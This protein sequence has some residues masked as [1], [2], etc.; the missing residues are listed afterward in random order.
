MPLA[1]PTN[2]VSTA[3]TVN[4]IRLEYDP[5][6]GADEYFIT[7]SNGDSFV[8]QDFFFVFTGLLNNTSHDFT[9]TARNSVNAQTSGPVSLLG[10]FTLFI[11]Q[12]YP[13][14]GYAGVKTELRYSLRN[15]LTLYPFNLV[16]L[17]EASV[18]NFVTI[19]SQNQYLLNFINEQEI[20][21]T[22]LLPDTEYSIRIT[23]IDGDNLA[24][25][26]AP[27]IEKII[28]IAP[29]IATYLSQTPTEADFSIVPA[30]GTESLLLSY[31]LIFNENSGLGQHPDWYGPSPHGSP[32]TWPFA[33][34]GT[35]YFKALM[36]T[37]TAGG[38]KSPAPLVSQA[39]TYGTPIPLSIE[40]Y[41]VT[42]N[43][44]IPGSNIGIGFS[45][46]GPANCEWKVFINDIQAT[47]PAPSGGIGPVSA[48]F[49]HTSLVNVKYTITVTNGINTISEDRFWVAGTIMPAVLSAVGEAKFF[50]MVDITANPLPAVFAPRN[51]TPDLRI[52]ANPIA[53]TANIYYSGDGLPDGGVP[54]ELEG[55]IDFGYDRAAPSVLIQDHLNYIKAVRDVVKACT[56]LRYIIG[57]SIYELPI[58]PDSSGNFTQGGAVIRHEVAGKPWISRLIIQLNVKTP[59]WTLDSSFVGTII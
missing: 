49:I 18:D 23:A 53:G 32:K 44:G 38:H 1:N 15:L 41:T 9:I 7:C 8:T 36:R 3:Q 28:T 17:I 26:A 34:S 50:L 51:A 33:S 27:W 45:V 19:A 59:R 56:G 6:V 57:T 20:V 22:S 43:S 52:T 58:Q 54:Y 46:N 42:P 2:F 40:S 25:R 55:V 5:V 31:Q 24:N 39:F 10:I 35:K 21:L 16:V 4:S 37:N 29:P 11:T 12:L 48:F 14:D 47:F 30:V 13:Y